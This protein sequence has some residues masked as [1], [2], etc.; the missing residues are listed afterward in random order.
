MRK[1]LLPAAA[2][3][4]TLAVLPMMAASAATHSVLTIS[5]VGGPNVKVGAI[6]KASLAGTN[7]AVFST[8]TGK[9]VTCKKVTFT[10]KVTK[11]PAKPGTAMEKLTNQTFARCTE[12]GISGATG[13]KSVKLNKLPYTT[14]IKDSKGDPVTVFGTNTTITLNTS[15]G[16]LSCTYKAKTTTGHASNATQTI[17]FSGQKFSLLSGPGECPKSGTFSAKFGPVR[18]TSVKGSPHVFVN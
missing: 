1:L 6:L 15:L 7:K 18:D 4:I 9:N 10:D 14:T 2:A 3:A 5:K 13:V 8:G 17:S 12:A 16:P 11:N